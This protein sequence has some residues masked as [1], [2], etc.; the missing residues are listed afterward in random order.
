MEYQKTVHW[1]DLFETSLKDDFE[2]TG[3]CEAKRAIML[4]KFGALPKKRR[5]TAQLIFIILLGTTISF[6]L[7]NTVLL[8]IQNI[9]V[10]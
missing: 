8:Q 5:L 3:L 1:C 6:G 2:A 7:Q 9:I 4:G 10:S